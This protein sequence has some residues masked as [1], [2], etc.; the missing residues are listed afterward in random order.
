MRLFKRRNKVCNIELYL[1]VLLEMSKSNNISYYKKMEYVK[2]LNNI[3]K[4]LS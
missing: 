2:M 1:N 3:I 4:N